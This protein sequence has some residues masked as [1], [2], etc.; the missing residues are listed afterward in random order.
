MPTSA[1]LATLFSWHHQ[2]G[3]CVTAGLTTNG[4]RFLFVGFLGKNGIVGEG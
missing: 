4:A 1:D 2:C 3:G